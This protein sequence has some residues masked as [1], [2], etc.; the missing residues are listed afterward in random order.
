MTHA[1]FSSLR[2]APAQVPTPTPSLE[3][4][5]FVIDALGYEEDFEPEESMPAQLKRIWQSATL[6]NDWRDAFISL[7]EGNPYDAACKKLE[8]V[9]KSILDARF[10]ELHCVNVTQF[11]V[12]GRSANP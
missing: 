2:K 4:Q 5:Q 12:E 1:L 3:V 9:L 6:R 10:S 8:A 7:K 11:D